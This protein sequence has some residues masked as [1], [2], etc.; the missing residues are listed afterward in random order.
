MKIRISEPSSAPFISSLTALFDETEPAEAS[1]NI[2]RRTRAVGFERRTR[3]VANGRQSRFRRL[4]Y[5]HPMDV[6]IEPRLGSSSAGKRHCLLASFFIKL[7]PPLATGAI[8]LRDAW[9]PKARR[10]HEDSRPKSPRGCA[11]AWLEKGCHL[12]EASL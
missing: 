9:L 2:E 5:F 10:E 1:S 8:I 3:L 4:I 6:G 12:I 7:R 11:L